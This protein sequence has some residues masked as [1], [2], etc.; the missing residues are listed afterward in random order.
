MA[1]A[2]IVLQK[3]IVTSENEAS[4]RCDTNESS[5]GDREGAIN[6]VIANQE[7]T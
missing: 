3:S 7:V 4:V 5:H 2:L 1:N 6:C